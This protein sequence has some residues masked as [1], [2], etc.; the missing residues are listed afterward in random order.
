MIVVLFQKLQL[1]SSASVWGKIGVFSIRINLRSVFM[2]HKTY[3]G[4]TLS[5]FFVSIDCQ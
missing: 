3:E 4:Q 2:V 1:V 5:P